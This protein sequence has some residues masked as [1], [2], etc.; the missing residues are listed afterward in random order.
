MRPRTLGRGLA[1]TA[2]I[3][4]VALGVLAVLDDPISGLWYLAY[5][6]AGSVLAVRRPTNPVGWLLLLIMVGFMGTTDLT[7]DQLATMESGAFV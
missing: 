4:A 5:L 3:G 6:L 1:A 7:P 2:T